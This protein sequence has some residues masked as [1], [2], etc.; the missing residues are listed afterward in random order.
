VRDSVNKVLSGENAGDVVDEAHGDWYL[1]P[2]SPSVA[3]GIV[4]AVDLAGYRN[5][6]VY[7][8][9]SMHVPPPRDAVRD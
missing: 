3:A 4:D 1:Q 6:P 9:R 7:I 5:R 2:S 8:R